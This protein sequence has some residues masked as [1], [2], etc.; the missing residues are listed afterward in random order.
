MIGVVRRCGA[1]RHLQDEREQLRLLYRCVAFVQAPA[2]AR[3][4]RGKTRLFDRLQ[5]IVECVHLERGHRVAIE[6]RHK[7]D[8][9]HRIALQ[10]AH[11]VEAVEPGHLDVEEDEVRPQIFDGDDCLATVTALTGN[12]DIVDRG[13]AQREAAAGE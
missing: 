12:L 13:E 10:P 6:S 11:D 3:D 1:A 5:Q 8:D 2:C 7:H 9:R 4:R